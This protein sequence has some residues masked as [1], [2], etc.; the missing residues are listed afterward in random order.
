[1]IQREK[2]REKRGE[3]RS[4]KRGE[5]REDR[6]ERRENDTL[7]EKA[8]NVAQQVCVVWREREEH[9]YDHD[10]TLEESDLR[11]NHCDQHP[12]NHCMHDAFSYK[13]KLYF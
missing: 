13:F 4:E 2:R 7:I 9:T 5:R 10:H 8:E 11:L 12:P 1:V 3:A 6:E